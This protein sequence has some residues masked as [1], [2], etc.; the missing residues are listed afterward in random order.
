MPAASPLDVAPQ[1]VDRPAMTRA[2]DSAIPQRLLDGRGRIL[3]CC[4]HQ[5]GRRGVMLGCEPGLVARSCGRCRP[6]WTQRQALEDYSLPPGPG[7]ALDLTRVVAEL[8]G[9]PRLRGRVS[10]HWASLYGYHRLPT[11]AWLP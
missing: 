10:L 7:G 1:R 6:S 3:G 2:G 8:G 5:T 11:G 9:D 4:T